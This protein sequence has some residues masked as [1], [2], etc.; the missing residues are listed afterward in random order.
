MRIA[1]SIRFL[2]LGLLLCLLGSASVFAQMETATLSGVIHDPKGAVVPDVEVTVT[3]IETGTV[4]TTKTNGAGIYAFTGLTPGHYHLTIRKP[5]FKE[6]AIK[7]FHLYVQDKLEQNFALEIG[8]VS[9]SVTV[10]A[11]IT[12]INTQDATVSTVIDHNFVENLPLNGRSFQT[13]INLTPGAVL[14]PATGTDPGQFSV[15]GQRTSTNYFTIDGVSANIGVSPTGGLLQSASGTSA[16]FG[17]TGGTNNLV[18]EDALQ[19]FRIQTST[20]APE[21]GRTP[22]AQIS[23]VTRAGT[24][25]FHGDVFEFLRNDKLD[26]NDWFGN[27]FGLPRPEERIN[28]FGGVLG[29]PVVKDRTFF[30]FSYEGQRLRLPEIG[31][32]LVPSVCARQQAP[33]NLQP[34]LNAYPLPNDQNAA[35]CAATPDAPLPFVEG[36]S[37]RSTLNAASLRLDQVINP[38]WLLFARYNYSP[39]SALQRGGVTSSLSTLFATQIRTQTGTLGSTWSISPSLTDELRFNYSWSKGAG[40]ASLDTFGGAVVPDPAILYPSP[41]NPANALYDFDIFGL[42]TGSISGAPNGSWITGRLATNYQKQL[43]ITDSLS[44]QKGAHAL[45]FGVDFRRLTPDYG[46]VGASYA[47]FFT[48]VAQASSGSAQGSSIS[49]SVPATALFRNLG[50]FAQDR[51][52]IVPRL[53]LT[54]GLR[55]DIDFSPSTLNG[56]ALSGVTNFNDPANLAL[57]PGSPLF[58]T[59]Y[60]GV[61]PRVGVAYQLRDNPDMGTVL[62]GGFGVFYDFASTEVGS[63]FVSGNYPFGASNDQFFP[64]PSFPLT[65]PPPPIALPSS[66]F[67]AFDPKL[68]L[69]RV[70]Q[71]NFTV[72]QSLGKSQSISIGDIGAV[73]RKLLLGDAFIFVNPNFTALAEEKNTG[74]SDYHALQV[75]YFRHMSRGLQALVAYTWSHSIDTGSSGSLG[76]NSNQYDSTL[77]PDINRGPSDFDIRNQL[78]AAVSYDIPDPHFHNAFARGALSNWSLENVILARSA[79]PVDIV[80]SNQFF[81]VSSIAVRPDRVPGQPLYLYG[82]NCAS[83]LLGLGELMPGQGCPGG[84]AFNPNAFQDP[85]VDPNTGSVTRQGN[86]GRNALRGFNAVQWDFGIRREFPMHEGSMRLQFRVELFNILNHPNFANPVGDLASLGVPS[87]FGLSTQTLAKGLGGNEPG[88]GGF[89]SVFQL[90]G[91]R[92]VQFGLKFLF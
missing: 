80:D 44:W 90:G 78:S 92:S 63:Q 69:P 88:G 41:V 79:L 61:A 82:G 6:I 33:S 9:E 29:G 68:E 19:E 20:Y 50:L 53:T 22:G 58:Q 46:P 26:A 84:K 30:F 67:L 40:S 4:V 83:T 59:R 56:P 11:R 87:G 5:G 27:Y 25:Q 57:A 74:T 3:R 91:P 72:E 2:C 17:V 47:A 16:G 70:Y 42:N 14:T 24:N 28:D 75:Q 85:P 86:L 81:G 32:T 10:E 12:S 8:S 73:G 62:R 76:S 64:S 7:E 65:S 38:R 52:K 77:G 21:F 13:L 60:G 49:S 71:W 1:V 34:Y 55:W 51:W 35:D 37:N 39:T 45:K 36:I 23:V 54:Y 89:A 15:N 66:R 31:N 48:D 43:N 18:S